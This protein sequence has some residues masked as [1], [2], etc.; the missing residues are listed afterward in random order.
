[1]LNAKDIKT[2]KSTVIILGIISIVM[3]VIQRS[4]YMFL[5]VFF[6]LCIFHIPAIISVGVYTYL[7]RK[8]LTLVIDSANSG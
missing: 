2:W 8:S 3:F 4:N 1:M 6:E 7:K 5:D